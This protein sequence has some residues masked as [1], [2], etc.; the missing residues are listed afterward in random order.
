V[1]HPDSGYYPQS[2]LHQ[3]R[4]VDL[5]TDSPL[6]AWTAELQLDGRGQGVTTE[7]LDRVTQTIAEFAAEQ[8]AEAGGVQETRATLSYTG[9]CD[10]VL[11]P[12]P[13][14]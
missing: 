3:V 6:F 11:L 1:P 7:L 12:E 13:E 4:V 5:Q 2:V 9:A 14:A 10:V 8:L